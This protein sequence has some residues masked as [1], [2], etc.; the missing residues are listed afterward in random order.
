MTMLT[1]KLADG[2]ETDIPISSV[3]LLEEG[4]DKALFVVYT[5]DRQQNQSDKVTD[6]YGFLKKK[7]ID[8]MFPK[9]IEVTKQVEKDKFRLFISESYIVARRDLLDKET[10]A[11][12]RLTLN[13]NGPI[14]SVDVLET[15]KQLDGED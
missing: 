13:V 15:R 8:G 9:G 4:P 7:L 12:T 10:P 3:L 1:L 2:G 14:F 6:N 5:L 11:K